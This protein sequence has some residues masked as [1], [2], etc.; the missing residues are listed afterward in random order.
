MMQQG[1]GSVQQQGGQPQ[2]AA[3][4]TF[5]TAVKMS[6]SFLKKANMDMKKAGLGKIDKAALKAV[7][8]GYVDPRQVLSDGK[9]SDNAKDVLH[10]ELGLA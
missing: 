2:E 10:A 4:F 6:D 1:L 5:E 3:P 8:E 7:A 9:V